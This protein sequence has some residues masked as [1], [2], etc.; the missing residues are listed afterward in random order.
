[1]FSRRLD[2]IP[3]WAC[4]LQVFALDAVEAPSRLLS[5]VALM[6]TLSSHCRHRPSAIRHRAWLVSL[7]TAYLPEV[8]DLPAMLSC[9]NISD[10][11]RRSAS[12][13]ARF[14]L[15]LPAVHDWIAGLRRAP[16]RRFETRIGAPSVSPPAVLPLV[17]LAALQSVVCVRLVGLLLVPHSHRALGVSVGACGFYRPPSLD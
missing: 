15:F 13:V 3:S 17:R 4:L 1:V 10:E 2:P 6:A 5:L 16:L 8:C 14:R 12:P 11:V 7:E 9:P